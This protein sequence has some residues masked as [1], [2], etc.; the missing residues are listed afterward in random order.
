MTKINLSF[1]H[2]KDVERRFQPILYNSTVLSTVCMGCLGCFGI[3]GK[4]RSMELDLSSSLCD[5]FRD[6]NGA[7]WS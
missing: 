4:V 1:P 7:P 2:F 5:A 3:I 6:R